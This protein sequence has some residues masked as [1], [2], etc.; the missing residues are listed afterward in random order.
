MFLGVTAC[1]LLL[2]TILRIIWMRRQ[3]SYGDLHPD[4]K[5]QCGKYPSKLRFIRGAENSQCPPFSWSKRRPP[6][7][8]EVPLFS[9]FLRSN[10]LCSAQFINFF[11]ARALRHSGDKFGQEFQRTYLSNGKVLCKHLLWASVMVP[12]AGFEPATLR[13]L[14]E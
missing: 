4:I 10:C 2:G 13:F 6:Q 12:E 5:R 11:G 1:G 14:I 7:S 8:N 9:K 3:G